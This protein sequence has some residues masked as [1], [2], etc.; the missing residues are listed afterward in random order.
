VNVWRGKSRGKKIW[1]GGGGLVTCM[2]LKGKKERKNG[3]KKKIV[4]FVYWV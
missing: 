4:L 3:V 2:V 1:G